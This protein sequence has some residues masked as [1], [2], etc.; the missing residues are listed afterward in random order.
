MIKRVIEISSQAYLFLKDSQMIIERAGLETAT[1]P[2]EDMGVLILDN[3][4]IVHT[5]GL[6]T[7]C[8]E[9]NVAVIICNAKHMPGAVFLPFDG[10]SLHTKTLALQV[11]ITEPT[12]K[13]LWQEI[14][15]AKIRAQA[16]ALRRV[17]GTNGP[18]AKFAEKVKSGDPNNLEARAARFYWQRLFSDTFRRNP[19][20]DGIN[21]LLNYGYALIR[22]ATARALVGTGLHPSLGLHHK[23]QY[24]HFCLADDLME[25]LRPIVDLRVYAL[26]KCK[27]TEPKLTPEVKRAILEILGTD[28]FINAQRL[29]LIP[30][31][32]RYAASVRKVICGEAKQPELP[33][34]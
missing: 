15:K 24:N 14:V 5:Q 3:H 4:S 26:A 1:V 21:S 29:P 22:A 18:L 23:N 17:T 10:N 25:P 11:Q 8:F 28:I 20:A 31:L 19:D 2:I 6:L 16:E 33:A 13:R 30:A 32:Q 9:N 27:T 34:L 7:A 12:R